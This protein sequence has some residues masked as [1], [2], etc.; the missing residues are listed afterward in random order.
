MGR[1]EEV[2]GAISGGILVI[3]SKHGRGEKEERAAMELCYKKTQILMDK[4]TE[5]HGTYICRQLLNGC[6]LTTR[7][8]QLYF[9]END[10]LIKTCVPCVQ[11]VIEILYEII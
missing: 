6:E 3:G 1:K 2:C 11:S 10:L 9:K 8:G 5:R 4:F 7:E